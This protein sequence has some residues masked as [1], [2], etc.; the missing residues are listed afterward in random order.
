MK[1]TKQ[2]IGEDDCGAADAR[3]P[4]SPVADSL[5]TTWRFAYHVRSQGQRRAVVQLGCND[6]AL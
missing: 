6:D 2:G 3:V 4:R 5:S 1:S